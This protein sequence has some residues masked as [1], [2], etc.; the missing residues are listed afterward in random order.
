MAEEKQRYRGMRYEAPCSVDPEDRLMFLA[1][2]DADGN[3]VLGVDLGHYVDGEFVSD[4]CVVIGTDHLNEFH[5][6][7]NAA[8][9]AVADNGIRLANEAYE[10][11]LKGLY[12]A[13]TCPTPEA[14]QAEEPSDF[15]KALAN[16]GRA[17][18]V[19]GQAPDADAAGS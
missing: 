15:L 11:T 1:F 14:T 13:K 8:L 3:V 17:F 4:A 7:I 12:E 6:G 5:T 19:F 9:A 18:G 10:E 16:A 2:E